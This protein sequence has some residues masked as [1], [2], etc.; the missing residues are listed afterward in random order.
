MR[1]T[2]CNACEHISITEFEQ[3]VAAA[4]GRDCPPHICT[5]YNRRVIHECTSPYAFLH[6]AHIHPCEDC[7]D[8]GY[9]NYKMREV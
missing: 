5:Y 3:M 8:D 1:N 2:D 4:G 9:A 7:E 6:S